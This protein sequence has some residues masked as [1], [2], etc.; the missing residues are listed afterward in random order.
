M[1]PLDNAGGGIYDIQALGVQLPQAIEDAFLETSF[2][3]IPTFSSLDIGE[4]QEVINTTD[5]AKTY[6]PTRPPRAP[7]HIPFDNFYTNELTSEQHIQFTLNNSNWLMSELTDTPVSESCA[8]ACGASINM[9]GNSFL[10]NGVTNNYSLT[11]GA[12]SYFWQI[13]S[14]GHL[15][16]LNGNN[17]QTVSLTTNNLNSTGKL[18][19]QGT[20]SSNRCSFSETIEKEIWVGAPQLASFIEFYNLNTG[21]MGYLCSYHN[22]NRYRFSLNGANGTINYEYKIK[23]WGSSTYTY[24]SSLKTSNNNPIEGVMPNLIPGTYQ[25]EIRFKN[26]CGWSPWFHYFV[27]Y[28]DCSNP[29]MFR[30]YPNPTSST[31]TIMNTQTSKDFASSPFEFSAMNRSAMV[32]SSRSVNTYRLFDF[33]GNLVISGQM[34]DETLIDVSKLKKGTYILKINANGEEETHQ[35]VIE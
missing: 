17:T 22:D 2:N 19:L 8:F 20:L 5:L 1:L 30:A 27:S 31:L 3:F 10:C 16:S 18:I 29:G 28:Q 24:I 12:E 35:I 13:L 33:S 9:S 23:L 4:G 6:S 7:K 14:G 11:A 21:A 32:T 26:S 25:F 34:D 15:A